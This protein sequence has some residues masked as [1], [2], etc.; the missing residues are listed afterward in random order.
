[1]NQHL[2]NLFAINYVDLALALATIVIG[3][4]AIKKAVEEFCQTFGIKLRY[5]E[6]K[7]EMKKCQTEVKTRLAELGL[8]QDKFEKQHG[9]NVKARD[10][11]NKE[12]MERIDALHKDIDAMREEIDRREAQKRFKK[13]R[14]DLLNFSDKIVRCESVSAEMISEIYD[15]IELYENLSKEYGFE[16]GRVNVSI[17]VIQQKYEELLKNGKVT[18]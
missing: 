8:R 3:F 4:V 5:L 11:F 7:Q 10:K 12:I 13:L 9:D 14:Y 18:R 1:M 17:S 2:I 16:N 6:E 15:E